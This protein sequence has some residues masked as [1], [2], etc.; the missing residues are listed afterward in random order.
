M[1]T[2]FTDRDEALAFGL[3]LRERGIEAKVAHYPAVS[4]RT[5]LYP[6]AAAAEAEIALFAER[7]DD[8]GRRALE[9]AQA[10][11]WWQ[12]DGSL[13][14]AASCLTSDLEEGER[15]G[16]ASYAQAEKFLQRLIAALSRAPKVER[17]E[18]PAKP[19]SWLLQWDEPED[20]GGNYRPTTGDRLQDARNWA[21]DAYRC[22]DSWSDD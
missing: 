3:A 11:P 1:T 21:E 19:E 18:S 12:G 17:V 13:A 7:G 2:S 22:G 16:A 8:L 15:N 5:A 6:D 9:W 14:H 10:S 4:E 20:T